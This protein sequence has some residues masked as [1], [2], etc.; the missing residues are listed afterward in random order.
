VATAALTSKPKLKASKNLDGAVTP[1]ASPTKKTS[2]L[3]QRLSAG[4]A[5]SKPLAESIDDQFEEKEPVGT[6]TVDFDEEVRRFLSTKV[7][8]G[9]PHF[10]SSLPHSRKIQRIF[11]AQS[12]NICDGVVMVTTSDDG[13]STFCICFHFFR[14]FQHVI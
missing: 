4:K 10:A 5:Q 8:V 13:W 2:K 3:S 6:P 12:G 1:T 14:L 9:G 7:M 11:R